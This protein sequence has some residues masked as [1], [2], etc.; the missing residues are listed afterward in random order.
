MFVLFVRY[1]SLS[2]LVVHQHS[3]HGTTHASTIAERWFSSL[4]TVCTCECSTQSLLFLGMHYDALDGWEKRGGFD[5]FNRFVLWNVVGA[6]K[7]TYERF[8]NFVAVLTTSLTTFMS[9][10]SCIWSRKPWHTLR[11]CPHGTYEKAEHDRKL[12]GRFLSLSRGRCVA[13]VDFT[14]ILEA[15]FT[16]N[17]DLLSL[18]IRGYVT[19]LG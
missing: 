15:S 18:N 4:N 11:S 2:V 3:S 8:A 13:T 9:P 12:F 14:Q 7:G 10:V 1:A 6:W 17:G 19:F 16:S 5:C